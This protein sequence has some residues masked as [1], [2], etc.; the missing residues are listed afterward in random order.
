MAYFTDNE[1]RNLTYLDFFLRCAWIKFYRT[2][3][4]SR[5]D[6]I[7]YALNFLSPAQENNFFSLIQGKLIYS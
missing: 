2:G 1:F 3:L 7:I 4:S 6:R 5:G